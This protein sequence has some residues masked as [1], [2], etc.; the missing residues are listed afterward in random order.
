MN[1]SNAVADFGRSLGMDL[2]L[3]A[4]GLVSLALDNGDLLCLEQSGD[5]LLVY[6]VA[7]FP[8]LSVQKCMQALKMCNARLQEGLGWQLQVGLQGSGADSALVFLFRLAKSRISAQGVEQAIAMIETFHQR[9][10]G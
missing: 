4:D 7:A 2:S 3:D 9:C 5:D 10:A 1:I 8:Y 6:R